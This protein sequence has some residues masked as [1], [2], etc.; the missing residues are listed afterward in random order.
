MLRNSSNVIK[1]PQKVFGDGLKSDL[2]A[3]QELYKII[4]NNTPIAMLFLE[5]DT[6]II[7][8]NKAY[9]KLTG[10]SQAQ[11]EGM[12]W[13][14]IIAYQEDINRIRDYQRLRRINPDLV[15]EEYD[16]II[17]TRYDELRNVT[18][19]V[20]VIPDSV[21]NLVSIVDITDRIRMEGEHRKLEERLAYTEKMDA[22]G[23]LAS[24]LGHDFNNILM[25]IQANTSILQMECSLEDPHS[26]RLARIEEHVKSG[27]NLTRQLLEF[28]KG[29]A[30]CIRTLF[31]NNLVRKSTA[32]FMETR[33]DI[34]TDLLLLDEL[35]P[36]KADPGQIEQVLI[37]I[38]INAGHAM[39]EGG[40]L[41]IRTENV[42]LRESEAKFLNIAPGEYINIS[43]SDTGTGMYAE[44]QKRV[45]EP[46]FTTKSKQG[47]TGLGL[48][49]AYGIIKNHGGTITLYSEPGQGTTFTIYLPVSDKNLNEEGQ[50]SSG[51]IRH[52]NGGI[53]IVDDDNNILD[54]LSDLLNNL[55]YAPFKAAS[56][57]EAVSIYRANQEKI[58]LV[59]LDLILPRMSGFYVLKLLRSINPD[60]K[61]VLSSG[62]G[63]QEK[64]HNVLETGCLGFLQKPYDLA[65]LSDIV[66]RAL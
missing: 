6:S 49:S 50:I 16:T 42:L 63:M 11:F 58:D 23:K 27:A 7:L 43:I 9:E 14:D 57:H 56:G 25:G 18:F 61:V 37:N 60:V 22:I 46:F 1:I 62:H 48:S 34:E 33:K 66:H 45:F 40:N 8:V 31:L 32:F 12:H 51:K 39:P 5:S 28:A 47:G 30:P 59:I 24:G 21:C 65:G 2:S 26:R 15:P 52:G 10:Y 44:I 3:C 4:F 53:L 54:T 17:K 19:H 55:G 29:S 13:V 64:V 20:T 35:S 36:V 41:N 38:L